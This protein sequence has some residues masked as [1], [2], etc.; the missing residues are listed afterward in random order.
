MTNYSCKLTFSSPRRFRS[1]FIG[2][3]S[4]TVSLDGRENPVQLDGFKFISQFSLLFHA[5]N[6]KQNE[7]FV[8]ISLNNPAD[9]RIVILSE[10]GV[11]EENT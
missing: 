8:P 7:T 2:G 6:Q 1:Q 4:G 9:R 11:G 5:Y 10:T 3:E